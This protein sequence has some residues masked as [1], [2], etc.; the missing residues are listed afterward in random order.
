MV[1]APTFYETSICAPLFHELTFFGGPE[2]GLEIIR[3]EELIVAGWPS[4]PTIETAITR[5]L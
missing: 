2:G 5:I 3:G 1:S 4:I